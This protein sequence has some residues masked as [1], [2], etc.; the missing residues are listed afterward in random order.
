MK[1]L[2]FFLLILIFSR[3]LASY[4]SAASSTTSQFENLFLGYQVGTDTKLNQVLAIMIDRQGKPTVSGVGGKSG[5]VGLNGQ[6]G[7]DGIDGAPGPIGPGGPPGVAGANGDA[8]AAGAN[9]TAGS[10]GTPG[11][12]GT[13]GVPGSRGTQGAAGPPGAPVAVV[14]VLPGDEHCPEGGTK[15]IGGDG[16]ISYACNGSA[17]ISHGTGTADIASCDSAINLGML[18]HFDTVNHR[19]ILDGIKVGDLSSDCSGHRLDVTLSTTDT[20]GTN[21]PFTCTVL[22]LPDPGGRDLYL[23]RPG[24]ALKYGES[25]LVV[26]LVCDP[27]LEVMDLRIL[28]SILGFQLL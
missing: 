23:A 27:L 8:G 16:G 11:T 1:K 26:T 20:L 10:A 15:F 22:A 18:S 25:G 2:T 17:L 12:P 14:P 19:F 3:G 9:G 5:F 7:K 4:P 24:Y 21:L 28:D 6:A 13:P